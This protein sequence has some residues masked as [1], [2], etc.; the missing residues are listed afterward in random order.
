MIIRGN[1]CYNPHFSGQRP[2]FLLW[3]LEDLKYYKVKIESMYKPSGRSA[4]KSIRIDQA[5]LDIIE[6][7]AEQE[8]L[9]TNAFIEN[10]LLKYAK[11]FMF[12]DDFS[13]M[14]LSQLVV[15]SFL[16]EIPDKKL[17]ELGADLGRKGLKN[18]LLMRGIEASLD[19]IIEVL[20]E[21][22]AEGGGWFELHSHSLNGKKLLHFT[23]RNGLKWSKFLSY[24]LESMFLELLD[25]EINLEMTDSYV[26]VRI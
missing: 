9:S 26:T 6:K 16:A 4:A 25:I 7:R 18:Y 1:S 10:V 5:L 14:T 8:N 3:R 20:D 23:H 21:N 2:R 22:Y 15:Q 19:S 17:E 12:L 11:H 24:Y 13:T